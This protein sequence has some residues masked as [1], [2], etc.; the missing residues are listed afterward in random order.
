M[1]GKS[2]HQALERITKIHF[3][4]S[5]LSK[6]DETMKRLV[7]FWTFMS[8]N[9]PLQLQMVYTMPQMYSAY[10]HFKRNVGSPDAPF[11]P[12]YWKTT[13]AFN[14]GA[15]IGG[16]PMYLQPDLGIDQVGSQLE[17]IKEMLGG[18]AGAALSELNPVALAPL[19]LAFKKDLY[20]DR[21]FTDADYS[22]AS[23]PIGNLVKALAT[24]VPGQSKQ[25]GDERL[26]SDNF[27]Q[28]LTSIIPPLSQASRLAP[29]ATGDLSDINRQLEAIVRYGGIPIRTLSPKQQDTEKR[30]QYYDAKDAATTRRK[31]AQRAAS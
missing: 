22:K 7:P 25:V 13:G 20:R 26:V 19:E 18:D 28:F 12:S 4:Y 27:M 10:E 23:G 3:D 30:N 16:M 6:L 2:V 11:T 8:R 5:Q 15:T 21:S 14:T 29:Q 24:I 1:A 31:L 17:S 9:L